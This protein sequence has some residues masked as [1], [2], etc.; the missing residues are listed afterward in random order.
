MKLAVLIFSEIKLGGIGT[1]A[2]DFA[3]LAS[4]AGY[5]AELINIEHRNKV[6]FLNAIEQDAFRPTEKGNGL[7]L[8]CSK[9]GSG[10]KVSGQ[11]LKYL[12]KF[13]ICI[14]VGVAPH[15]DLALGENG[16]ET[17]AY[18]EQKEFYLSLLKNGQKHIAFATDKFIDKYYPWISPHLN[19]F[20]AIWAFAEPYQKAIL[21]YAPCDVLPIAPLDAWNDRKWIAPSSKPRKLF[22]PHQFRGW[23]NPD[24]FVQIVRLLPL[25]SVR[26]YATGSGL[27]F[28]VF[29]K[30]EIYK[31]IV[32]I[33][34]HKPEQR[35]PNG[36]LE[37]MGFVPIADVM[38]EYDAH[39]TTVD[40]TGVSAKLRQPNSFQGNYQCATIES[41]LKTCAVIKFTTTVQPFNGIPKDC[42]L[43]LEPGKAIEE[44]AAT[45]SEYLQDL[46]LADKVARNALDWVEEVGEPNACFAKM[47]GGQ[48]KT[49]SAEKKP[50]QASIFG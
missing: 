45:I 25:D 42:V 16:E 20:S 24:L 46:T 31:Q 14:W 43:P 23:K 3:R 6:E 35:N 48:N 30:S 8:R 22:W 29:S 12:A 28:S 26:M 13:D 40:L 50:Q 49:V 2:H 9:L 21:Q 32:K 11:S 38:R 18:L 5:E 17:P 15:I 1:Q 10:K 4:A 37:L 44:Y 27:E 47:I 36:K 7:K 19:L 34:V 33:D 39:A 41:F